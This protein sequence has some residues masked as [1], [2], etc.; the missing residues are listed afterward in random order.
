MRTVRTVVGT[1]LVAGLILISG[2]FTVP[3]AAADATAASVD[4]TGPWSGTWVYQNQSRGA[5]TADA[6]FQQDGQKLSG[7]LIMY[8]PGGREYSVVGVISGN[9]IKLSQ[10]TI[11]TLTVNGNEMS[12]ILDGWDNAR[13]TLRR[14]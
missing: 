3:A 13:I 6:T 10:P 12:G 7:N 14:K 11:G 9:E 4:L 1:L 8:S 2:S 5:G